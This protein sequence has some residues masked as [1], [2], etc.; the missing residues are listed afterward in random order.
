MGW[1]GTGP[2]EIQAVLRAIDCRLQPWREHLAEY[3]S[4]DESMVQV[5]ASGL[6]GNIPLMVLSHDPGN[7][8]DTFLAAMETAWEDSQGRWAYLSTDSSR[9]IAKGSHHN[10]QLDRPDVVVAAIQKVVDKYKHRVA[11][12]E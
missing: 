3:Y 9:V 1:C 4:G 11:A 8:T 12:A 10:I 7:P 5:R 2:P 6:L